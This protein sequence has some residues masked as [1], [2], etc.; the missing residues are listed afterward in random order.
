MAAERYEISLLVF[1]NSSLARCAHTWNILPHSMRNFV[2]PSGQTS[3]V[4]YLQTADRRPQSAVCKCD[5]PVKSNVEREIN[6]CPYLGVRNTP[7]LGNDVTVLHLLLVVEAGWSSVQLLVV[8]YR[9]RLLSCCWGPNRWASFQFLIERAISV[10]FC[11]SGSR[12][13]DAQICVRSS[14]FLAAD[15]H[16]ASPQLPWGMQQIC[17]PIVLETIFMPF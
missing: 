4:C 5:T 9:L 3:G 10:L 2:S 6:I 7:Y 8:D 15:L 14:M 12:N 1:K 11:S 16:L 17:G 13:R